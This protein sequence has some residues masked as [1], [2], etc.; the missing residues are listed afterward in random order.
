VLDAKGQEVVQRGNVVR[1][2]SGKVLGTTRGNQV[3][4]S[5]GRA[6]G[7]LVDGQ[8]VAADG[9]VLATGVSVTPQSQLANTGPRGSDD[10]QNK[11]TASRMVQFIPG[12]TGKGGVTPM[13][14]IRLE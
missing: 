7:T 6:I 10:A 4:D 1:D 11:I 5:Q 14:S 3:I 8:V 12:G 2:A 9:K 13:Q